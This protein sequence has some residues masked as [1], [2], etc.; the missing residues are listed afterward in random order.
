MNDEL[1]T[2]RDSLEQ[3][4]D[5]RL[6]V[7]DDRLTRLDRE[8]SKRIAGLLQSHPENK[9]VRDLAHLGVG[10]RNTRRLLRGTLESVR[11]DTDELIAGLERKSN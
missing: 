8:M 6:G 11:N 7:L 4:F 2:L 5:E 1:V 10:L 3:D 9:D